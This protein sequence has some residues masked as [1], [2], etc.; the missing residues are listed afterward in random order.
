S[1]R[2]TNLRRRVADTFA[3]LPGTYW[4]LWCATLLDRLGGFVIPF[5]AL[6]LTT[7]RGIGA[8][9]A[10][11]ILSLSGAAGLVGTLAGGVL[12]DRF[13]R[14]GILV[15]GMLAG[16]G[17]MLARGF[18]P[19][20]PLI[21]LLYGAVSFAGGAVRPA[22]SALVADVVPAEH[23]LRA[24]GLLHW[25]VN[26]GFSVAPIVAGLMVGKSYLAL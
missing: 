7:V 3:G 16:G 26:I 11:L 2:M 9:A 24:Y 14:R 23:R 15:A 21:A 20:L 8:D 18:A 22:A 19:P 5:M 12:A 4:V 13:G 10:G 1:G 6:Y 17:P 25:A